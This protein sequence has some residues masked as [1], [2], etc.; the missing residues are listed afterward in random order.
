MTQGDP[1]SV[2]HETNVRELFDSERPC[3]LWLPALPAC[4]GRQITEAL[5]EAGAHTNHHWPAETCRGSNW[6]PLA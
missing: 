2:T 3:P 4:Y 5:A 1:A 6:N